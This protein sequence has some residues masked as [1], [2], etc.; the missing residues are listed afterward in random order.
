MRIFVLFSVFLVGA[1][2]LLSQQSAPPAASGTQAIYAAQANSCQKKFDYL[3][4]NG[5]K[6][7]PDQK[8][9]VITE[10]EINAW[11]ASGNAELPKGVKKLQF[12]GE[13]GVIDA[14][15]YVDFDEVTADRRSSNPLLS[16]FR[17]TH[18]VQAR[19]HASGSGGTGQVHIDS[20]SLDG[21]GVPRVA[22]E[23]FVDKYI[24]EKHPEI[25]LDSTFKLP[26][27]I[28]TATVG[29]RQLTVTQK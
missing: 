27:R 25:G 28:D 24:T 7:T 26:Y 15:A 29:P 10:N 22:L 18:E 14:T 5:S 16:L 6:A 9:T 11:L 19:A 23:Y 17:G 21:V 2:A 12:K 1:A 8:P 3:Q 13:T 20:V 4:Q